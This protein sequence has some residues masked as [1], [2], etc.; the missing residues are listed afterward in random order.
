MSA[1]DQVRAGI[2]A[3]I[4]YHNRGEELAYAE[5]TAHDRAVAAMRAEKPARRDIRSEVLGQLTDTPQSAETIRRAIGGRLR[6][7]EQVLRRSPLYARCVMG[8]WVRVESDERMAA[9]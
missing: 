2:L 8:A 3:R 6:D 4:D 9:E 7:V 1:V 5:L